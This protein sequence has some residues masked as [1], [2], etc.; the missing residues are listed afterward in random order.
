MLLIKSLDIINDVVLGPM[1]LVYLGVMRRFL[2]SIWL[3]PGMH[4]FSHAEKN[5]VSE[6]LISLRKSY[7]SEYRRK[8]RSLDEIGFWKAIEFLY[9]LLYSGPLV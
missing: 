6:M 7:P 8:G 5:K 1:H 2:Q 9:F 4:S 3:S